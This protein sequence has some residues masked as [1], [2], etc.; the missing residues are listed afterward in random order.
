[1]FLLNSGPKA[2]R[3]S[4]IRARRDTRTESPP[5]GR[6]PAASARTRKGAPEKVSFSLCSLQ[7][8]LNHVEERVRGLRILRKFPDRDAAVLR[9]QLR[10]QGHRRFA[11]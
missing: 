2:R 6:R 1:M 3:A 9:A 10:L 8:V 11:T 4:G 5:P 7:V